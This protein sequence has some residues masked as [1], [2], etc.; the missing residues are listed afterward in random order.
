MRVMNTFYS[1]LKQVYCDLIPQD[2]KSWSEQ[3]HRPPTRLHMET[4]Q[5]KTTLL[6]AYNQGNGLRKITRNPKV[7]N[8][9]SLGTQH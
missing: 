4:L 3:C 7:P 2:D 5:T 1:S 9:E 6:H 8:H